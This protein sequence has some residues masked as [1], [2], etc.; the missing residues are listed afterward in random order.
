M[1]TSTVP[2]VVPPVT[3]SIPLVIRIGS[4]NC[5]MIGKPVVGASNVKLGTKILGVPSLFWIT[6][7]QAVPAALHAIAIAET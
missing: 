1:K 7:V 3:M 6:I 2:A 5:K 4:A